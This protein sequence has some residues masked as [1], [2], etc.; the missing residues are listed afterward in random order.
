MLKATEQRK[1]IKS[2]GVMLWGATA[3]QET[4]VPP[5]GWIT[6]I[7]SD[8]GRIKW[9]YHD[10]APVVAGMTPTASGLLLTGDM[11]GNF[12]VFDSATGRLL[13]KRAT[14][15][16]L[17]G[18]V[19]TYEIDGRQYI[20]FTSGNV[21]RSI[22]GAVGK[23][24]VVILA[25]SPSA[26][27]A[28]RSSELGYDVEQGRQLYTENC[29]GC[30]GPTGEGGVGKSLKGLHGRMTFQETVERIENP[31]SPMPKL[32]PS[33]LGEQAVGEIAAY[34]RSF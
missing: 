19:I 11:A 9:K 29:A 24:S 4:D 21:S 14:G 13:H 6:G 1:F 33:P 34:I 8:T 2:Q 5:T 32:Y 30:H 31:K 18:G 25:L 12:L 28:A 16:A 26:A 3:T 10:T 17:A 23:P 27:A 22:F 20:A 7:D 15:G